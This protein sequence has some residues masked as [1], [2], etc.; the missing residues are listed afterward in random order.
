MILIETNRPLKY[1]SI[2]AYSSCDSKEAEV[3]CIE[4]PFTISKG[5]DGKYCAE[6]AIIVCF[7]D[8]EAAS[9]ICGY[10]SSTGFSFP[11]CK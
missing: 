2:S 8:A 7:D 3:K 9:L 6:Y 1:W 10:F 4:H 11:F 5:D